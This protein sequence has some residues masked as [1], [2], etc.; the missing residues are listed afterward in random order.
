MKKMIIAILIMALAV[1]VLATPAFAAMVKTGKGIVDVGN[2]MCPVSGDAV[3][4]KNFVTYK[5]KRYG[6]CCPACKKPF[7]KNPE[8]YIA[9]MNAKSAVAAAP[10]APSTLTAT[11]IVA[12]PAAAPMPG[13][14]EE[15][16]T[17]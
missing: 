9:Q 3:S 11:P 16:K 2:K 7:L 5:G 13:M 17:A 8:K 6:L 12:K 1:P 4:G 14:K 10:T 15:K